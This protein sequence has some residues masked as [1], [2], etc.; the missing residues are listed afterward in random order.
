MFEQFLC[1]RVHISKFLFS[2]LVFSDLTN[3]AI[4]VLIYNKCIKY[5][6]AK[7]S[8]DLIKKLEFKIRH[9]ITIF[10]RRVKMTTMY[11]QTFMCK[12]FSK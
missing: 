4:G 12:E 6:C 10:A 2:D 1:Y 5:Q 11:L 3:S 9:G 7:K 8:F